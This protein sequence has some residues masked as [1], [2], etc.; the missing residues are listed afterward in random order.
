MTHK[1]HWD[2]ERNKYELTT[3]RQIPPLQVYLYGC[4]QARIIGGPKI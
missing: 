4:S 2:F 3:D 1:E